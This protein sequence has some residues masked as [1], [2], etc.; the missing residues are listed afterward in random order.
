MQVKAPICWTSW[1]CMGSKWSRS[2][3]KKTIGL[4]SP[5][6]PYCGIFRAQTKKFSDG[7]N[8]NPFLSFEVH[9][10]SSFQVL[11][12]IFIQAQKVS[13][14]L[15]ASV[16]SVNHKTFPWRVCLNASLLKRFQGAHLLVLIE[17]SFFLVLT[18][19]G[20][21]RSTIQHHRPWSRHLEK[22]K[23]VKEDNY[24]TIMIIF[25][26]EKAFSLVPL[27]KLIWR[28]DYRSRMK[29]QLLKMR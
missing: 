29:S 14:E 27:K 23:A 12:G 19:I 15:F 25:H 17:V 16:H 2:P 20:I 7:P 24:W 13:F 5:W 10:R 22:I 26:Y 1:L 9:L 4:P 6:I 28:C 18:S 3:S 21:L 8:A 11:L